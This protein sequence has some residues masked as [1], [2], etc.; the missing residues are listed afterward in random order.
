[1]KKI[2]IIIPI[3][4]AEKYL[5]KC[6]DS[7]V[8]QTYKNLEIILVDDGSKDNSKLICKKYALKD[9]RIKLICNDNHGVG[10]S[11]NCG[12]KEA[13][14]EGVMFIDSDDFVKLNYVEKMVSFFDDNDL[15][16]CNIYN[17]Y[18]KYN[19]Y[20][21]NELNLKYLTGNWN[22][23][24]FLLGSIIFY[25]HLK[26]YKTKII[27]DNNIYFPEDMVT[28]ED[29]IFNYKYLKYVKKY[30]YINDALYIYSHR[31]NMSLSKL[32][33]KV[34]FDSEIKALMFKKCYFKE[35]RVLNGN[36]MIMEQVFFL[37]TK[38]INFDDEKNNFDKYKKRISYLKN[39]IP[40]KQDSF[41][42]KEKF[43]CILMKNNLFRSIYFFSILTMYKIRVKNFIKNIIYNYMPLLSKWGHK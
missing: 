7:V 41:I 39:F 32:K 42:N 43:L 11:R 17:F 2:S 18:E 13:N 12:I 28:A 33:T 34:S 15:V 20:V 10:Y 1:M 4:N 22:K 3:Y 19:R 30:K 23:D 40:D 5:V 36:K 29:Q 9:N 37:V 27:K 21:F 38:Y 6:L 25:P 31:E 24:I 8:K 14:G 16:I 26:L 35:M